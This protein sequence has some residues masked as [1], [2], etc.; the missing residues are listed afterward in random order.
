MI[1]RPRGD[2]LGS[3]V[4]RAPPERWRG[5]APNQAM[6]HRHSRVVGRC[7][8][9]G[10]TRVNRA[11]LAE[12]IGAKLTGEEVGSGTAAAG[13]FGCLVNMCWNETIWGERNWLRNYGTW[14]QEIRDVGAR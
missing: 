3:L 9:D 11:V 5:Q 8:L 7:N 12:R 10:V 13:G 14:V 6:A 2:S 1:L 4:R